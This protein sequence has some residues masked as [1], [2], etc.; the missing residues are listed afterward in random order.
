MERAI[1]IL[2]DIS[3]DTINIWDEQG[4]FTARRS[5]PTNIFQKERKIYVIAD[6]TA[7]FDLVKHDKLLKIL[8]KHLHN[9]IK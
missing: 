7:A 5:T 2:E 8:T 4:G 1:N 3:P 9:K 6:I